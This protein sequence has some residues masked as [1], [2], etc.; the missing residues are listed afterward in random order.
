[1]SSVE[2]EST[3]SPMSS[4]CTNKCK[5]KGCS[6]AMSSVGC[7]IVNMIP[8][9]VC[10]EEGCNHVFDHTCQCEW[11]YLQYKID[12]PDGD[13]SMSCYDSDGKKCCMHHHPCHD[14]ALSKAKSALLYTMTSG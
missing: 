10:G 5:E 13:P 1:M 12:F 2:V 6:W 8:T 3:A 14:I 7:N 4:A 9:D 11:E